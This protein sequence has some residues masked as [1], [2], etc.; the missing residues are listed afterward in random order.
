MQVFIS[1]TTF[2]EFSREP[3]DILKANGID[4]ILNPVK[5]KLTEQEIARFLSQAPYIG[6]IAGTEPLTKNV[7]SCAKSLKVISRVGVG[8]E[9]IDLS[10]AEKLNIRVLN[11]PLVLVDSVAELT[12]GLI[13]DS[14]RKIALLDRQIRR[15]YWEKKSGLLFKG[16]T[17]GII[18]FGNIGSRVALLSKAFGANIIFYDVKTV[19]S[20]IAKQVS[21]DTL[22]RSADI[23]SVHSSCTETI[24]SRNEI[25]NM[26]EGVILINTS[27]G[28]AVNEEDL[29]HGLQSRKISFAALDVFD[30]EPYSGKLVDLENCVLTPH[31]GSYAKEARM[32]MEIE[33]VANLINAL[34]NKPKNQS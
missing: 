33:A 13:M 18:G 34:D 4:F 16:K 9:N 23:I 11:T 27:R 3:L 20:D 10:E 24:I 7:L 19:N 21:L 28:S 6:L 12:I 17:L 26:K 14:L 2:A 22:I 5:R 8:K 25:D 29:Y 32:Q 1:T 15:K 30:K 31:I